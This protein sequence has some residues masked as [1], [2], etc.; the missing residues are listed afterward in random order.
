MFVTTAVL[1]AG[2]GSYDRSAICRVGISC[3]CGKLKHPDHASKGSWIW[4]ILA[5]LSML[6]FLMG[7][8]CKPYAAEPPGPNPSYSLQCCCSEL[9]TL[10]AN[11][12]LVGIDLLLLWLMHLNHIWQRHLGA[13]A[14]CG[15]P[16][17]H[18]LDLREAGSRQ[19]R[20]Q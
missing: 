16:V 3:S 5:C 19:Y 2:T 11:V 17:L 6:P 15:I 1:A 10:L 14:A 8:N 12:W 7:R 13:L 4:Q 9:C 20:P 18:D